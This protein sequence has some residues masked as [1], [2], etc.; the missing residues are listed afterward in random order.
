MLLVAESEHVALCELFLRETLKHSVDNSMR[1]LPAPTSSGRPSSVVHIGTFL[2]GSEQGT[3]KSNRRSLPILPVSVA[4]IELDSL[5]VLFSS[6]VRRRRPHS[7]PWGTSESH[8]PPRVADRSGRSRESSN[9]ASRRLL[10]WAKS[11]VPG[12]RA[13]SPFVAIPSA[14]PV[15]LVLRSCSVPRVP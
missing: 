2:T 8:E 12:S 4:E 11:G 5:V 10:L 3:R 13:Y 14:P 1:L 7:S 15:P 9:S 6:P